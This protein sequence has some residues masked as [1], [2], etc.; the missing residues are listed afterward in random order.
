MSR[1]KGKQVWGEKIGVRPVSAPRIMFAMDIFEI[2]ICCLH[3]SVFVRWTGVFLKERETE[4][5]GRK[6]REKKILFFFPL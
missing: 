1:R 3:F 4:R 2:A 6:E 5:G